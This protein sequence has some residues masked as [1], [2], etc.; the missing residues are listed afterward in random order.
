M[1]KKRDEVPK[2]PEEQWELH[3][4]FS[5]DGKKMLTLREYVRT[6]KVCE[7]ED[8][9]RTQ[10]TMLTIKRIDAQPKLDI[11][12]LSGPHHTRINKELALDHLNNEHH[13]ASFL[14]DIER[15]ILRELIPRARM[16][17]QNQSKTQ[18]QHA[19]TQSRGDRR[20]R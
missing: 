10:I 18:E 9:T 16:E 15:R 19:K 1:K 11:A 4:G 3:A 8:L 7:L 12:V 5:K 13:T 17:A 20:K 2:I 6:A 14:R